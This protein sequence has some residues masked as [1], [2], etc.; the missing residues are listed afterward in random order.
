[1]TRRD[2]LALAGLAALTPQLQ[3]AA[4]TKWPIT[5]GPGTPKLCLGGPRDPASLRGYRQLGIDHLI[6]GG[7]PG[8][9]PWSVE[10][11][12]AEIA[13]CKEAGVTLANM[14]MTGFHNAIYN[15]PGR[16][17]DIENVIQTIRNAGRAGLPVIEYNW[18][19]HRAME[20][21]FEETGRAGLGH[22]GF[23][24]ERMR[25]LPPLPEEG[26]HSLDTM[27]NNIT[28]FLKAVVPEAEKAGVRLALHPN[29]P[30][31]L[32]SRG[33]GQIMSTL[34]GWKRLIDI[35]DSPANGITFDCGVTRELG[36]DPVPVLRY[37]GERKR[38]NHMHYRNVIVH[39]PYERYTEV[40]I[41]E[42]QVD[43]FA[44][45]KE[46]VRLKYTGPIY[47]EHPRAL[48]YDRE[49]AKPAGG[50]KGYPGGGGFAG[51]AFCVAYARAMLQAAL[52][53]A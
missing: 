39:K 36:E 35:F 7:P 43:M 52:A 33:S 34:A 4:N 1:M 37:F 42:G 49:A 27:W 29:D 8:P 5:E 17:R 16:D 9:L 13:K 31:P 32:Y 10:A 18:Y 38:I 20:G 44:V 21:Y 25:N 45:M 40:S 46:V 50:I 22:T 14:M 15:R 51:T 26:A 47:P 23:D 3:A 30:P 48:D 11:I 53:S 19:A 6:G 2:T 41:D 28:Y 12:A 24:Y